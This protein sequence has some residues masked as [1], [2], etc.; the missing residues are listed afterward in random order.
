MLQILHADLA[1][2]HS[3]PELTRFQRFGDGRDSK[4]IGWLHRGQPK[5]VLVGKV[6]ACSS[7]TVALNERCGTEVLQAGSGRD[8]G[9]ATAFRSRVLKESTSERMMVRRIVSIVLRKIK[10]KHLSQHCPTNGQFPSGWMAQVTAGNWLRESQTS[11][12]LSSPMTLSSYENCYL[13]PL[14]LKASLGVARQA[15]KV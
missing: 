11:E 13:F 14:L 8:Q 7:G 3:C 2:S 15:R 1:P 5:A 10:C 9:L 4:L 12:V 6:M